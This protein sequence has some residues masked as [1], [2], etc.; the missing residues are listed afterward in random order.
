VRRQQNGMV[1]SSRRENAYGSW[2]DG[3]AAEGGGLLKAYRRIAKSA[4]A[5]I[6]E[7][8]FE[9]TVGSSTCRYLFS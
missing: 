8:K 1:A 4:L 9:V 2:R 7:E 3:R 6:Y 5:L